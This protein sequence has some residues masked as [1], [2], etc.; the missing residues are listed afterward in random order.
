MP[1]REITP[2][3][4]KE[5]GDWI[6]RE[7][8]KIPWDPKSEWLVDWAPDPIAALTSYKQSELERLDVMA[9]SIYIKA[10]EYAIG[11]RNKQPELP[12]LP[13]SSMSSVDN[14][15]LME[16]WCI[17]ADKTM[18]PGKVPPPLDTTKCSK[19]ISLNMLRAIDSNSKR[20]GIRA[21]KKR[22]DRL[23]EYFRR[24]DREDLVD[25]LYYEG[26]RIKTKMPYRSMLH[27]E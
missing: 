5:L 1:E 21:D 4:P 22:F 11:L 8:N 18:R 12:K 7:W 17:D 14:M 16:E 20:D 9:R 15:Q 6:K 25:Q 19:G 23:K 2:Q 26:G 13:K 27:P 10:R 24:Q 3:T